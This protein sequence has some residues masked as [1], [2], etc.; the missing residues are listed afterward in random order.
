MTAHKRNGKV[1]EKV[2]AHGNLFA[3][4]SKTN[5]VTLNPTPKTETKP[6]PEIFNPWSGDNLASTVVS[7]HSTLVRQMNNRDSLRC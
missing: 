7:P 5:A 4:P 3:M 2:L 6:M 1:R